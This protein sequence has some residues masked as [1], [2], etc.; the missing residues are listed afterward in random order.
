MFLLFRLLSFFA[1]LSLSLIFLSVSSNS[2]LSFE[3]KKNMFL[4]CSA[5]PLTLVCITTLFSRSLA[6][7]QKIFYGEAEFI[8]QLLANTSQWT[9]V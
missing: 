7:K 5:W 3:T 1:V 6:A 4:P 2:N 9:Y 8:H